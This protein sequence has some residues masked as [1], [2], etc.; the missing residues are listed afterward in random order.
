M[1][2][3]QNN[4]LAELDSRGRIAVGREAGGHRLFIVDKR[5]SGVIILTPARYVPDVKLP[6]RS[7]LNI[8]EIGDP[9]GPAPERAE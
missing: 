1:G 9:P 7:D 5:P 4:R 2:N 6:S 8:I 3:E